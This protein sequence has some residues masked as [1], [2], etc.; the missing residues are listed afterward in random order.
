MFRMEVNS[1]P[2]W[3]D[4]KRG[5]PELLI[6]SASQ[7]HCNVR[8][9]P[10]PPGKYNAALQETILTLDRP[11]L[12]TRCNQPAAYI[13]YSVHDLRV[14]HRKLQHFKAHSVSLVPQLCLSAGS[15]ARIH[16]HG[17]KRT[18]ME[19]DAVFSLSWNSYNIKQT[20]FKAAISDVSEVVLYKHYL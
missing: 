5:S 12:A 7:L 6:W 2:H 18:N 15:H 19:T 17:N 4:L 20:V 8:R 14:W 1:F 9:T 10:S 13:I 11:S 16:I 3:A